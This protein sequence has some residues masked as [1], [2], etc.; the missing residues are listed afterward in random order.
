MRISFK[1]PVILFVLLV[2]ASSLHAQ[3]FP[4]IAVDSSF[5]VEYLLGQQ[6]NRYQDPTNPAYQATRFLVPAANE[7]K[8]DLNP[9]FMVLSG[10][11]ELTPV[12]VA[13]G[14]LAGCLSVWEKSIPTQRVVHPTG[15]DTY[16]WTTTPD[17]GSWE[18]AGLLNLWNA[19]GYRF[20]VTAGYR[21]EK[22]VW[23]G[24]P[25][26]PQDG[27]LVDEFTSSIP[28]IGLQTSMVYP[29]WKARFELIGSPF[30]NRTVQ[31]TQGR[32]FTAHGS[33]NR[34]GLV[35][36]QIEGSIGVSRSVYLGVN[37]LYSFQEVYGTATVTFPLLT[38][39]PNGASYNLYMSQTIWRT[40][41]DINILF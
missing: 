15:G 11:V 18:A 35:E 30:M 19:E 24:D 39:A 36:L 21:N 13:S 10:M 23:N 32:S 12:P 41:M 27:S 20:S 26:R 2:V 38:T 8:I 33:A 3:D 40:G 25:Q 17:F 4:R 31:T 34:G 6:F 16:P 22:W 7:L 28:F 5:R 9:Q 1:T 29:W 14:R 37:A